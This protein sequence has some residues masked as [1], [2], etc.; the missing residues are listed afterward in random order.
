MHSLQER[1]RPLD[2]GQMRGIEQEQ[3]SFRDVL[4]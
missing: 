3:F 4:H 1:D 2:I